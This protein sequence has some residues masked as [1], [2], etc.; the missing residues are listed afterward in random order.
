M[1][2]LSGRKTGRIKGEEKSRKEDAAVTDNE[3][4]KLSRKD[5][6][7]LLVSQG[8]ELDDLQ[9]KLEKA[10]AA[11]QDRQICIEKVGSIAEAALEL[12]GVFE[13]AQAA[14]RQY[15]EN[16][17]QRSEFIEE[18]CA[19][20]EA[21]CDQR[22]KECRKQIDRQL[23]EAEQI[24]K[25]LEEEAKQN[26]ETLETE[27]KQKCEA[28]EAETKQNCEAM[29]AEAK[30]KSEAYWDEISTRLKAFYEE[31]EALKKMMVP[32]GGEA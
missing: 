31:H 1:I 22:E 20:K 15:L 2:G 28:L 24:A 4:R 30:Q 18:E 17:R 19:R 26:C 11:L 10:E 29:E 9:S 5:L 12:N 21:D 6:L 32:S 3:L 7:E 23:R 13:A 14:A 8:R 27:T 16:V 25:K